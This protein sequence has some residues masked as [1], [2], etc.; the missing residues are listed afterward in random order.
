MHNEF[1]RKLEVLIN[2]HSDR[3]TKLETTKQILVDISLNIE[4]YKATE[5]IGIPSH[6][7]FPL[8]DKIESLSNLLSGAILEIKLAQKQT[9]EK[10]AQDINK[11]TSV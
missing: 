9:K 7:L 3:Q 10:L 6:L 8:G 11:I 1:T 4:T 2:A 5:I